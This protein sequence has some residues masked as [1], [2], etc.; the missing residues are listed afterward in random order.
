MKSLYGVVDSLELTTD[1]ASSWGVSHLDEGG[2]VGELGRGGKS[3]NNIASSRESRELS[4][5]LCKSGACLRRPASSSAAMTSVMI[6]R[7]DMLT[8]SGI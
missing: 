7:A 2:A 5:R 1:G 3:I 8:G 4:I 6:W